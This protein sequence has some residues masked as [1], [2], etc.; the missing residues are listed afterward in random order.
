M[1]NASLDALLQII[2]FITVT[3]APKTSLEL[4]CKDAKMSGFPRVHW[5]YILG[6]L[7]WITIELASFHETKCGLMEN[8]PVPEV[9][10]SERENILQLWKTS[11]FFHI[12]AA[13]KVGASVWWFHCW[14][15]SLQWS[16]WKAATRLPLAIWRLFKDLNQFDSFDFQANPLKQHLEWEGGGGR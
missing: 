9:Q 12:C 5:V 6:T 16:G 7:L 1:E 10:G 3:S 14:S 2:I 13:L 8:L 4:G 15:F 11:S